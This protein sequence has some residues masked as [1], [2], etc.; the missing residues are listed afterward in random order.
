MEYE[1]VKE[2]LRSTVYAQLDLSREV[3]DEELSRLI[4]EAV[5]MKSRELCITVE[6]RTRLYQELFNSMRKLDILQALVEDA[7]V[8]EIMV[9]GPRHIFYEKKGELFLWDFCFDSVQRLEDVIQQIAA[10]SNRIV[11]EA[12]PIVDARLEDG[13]RVNVVLK[14][15]ALNGPILTIRRFPEKPLSISDLISLGAL[16]ET[17]AEFL[18]QLV[19]A[20]YNI[21]ISGGTGSGK[22]TFLNA[23]SGLIPKKERIITIEDSAELQLLGISNLVKLETRNANV[24]GCM[25]ITI[26]D[27]IRTSLRMRPE[28]FRII[29]RE[30]YYSF[31]LSF[32]PS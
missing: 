5:R 30:K 22:T 12:S 14:P 20:G 13:S 32:S 31:I 27:L 15:V 19:F 16:D 8:T 7:E 2:E 24:E 9:N 21:F 25:E 18:S 11:N 26:R 3:L 1:A 17:V 10:K 23:L 6:E 28:P 29:M 4:H